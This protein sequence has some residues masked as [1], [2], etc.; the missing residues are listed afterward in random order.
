MCAQAEAAAA[1]AAAVL[2]RLSGVRFVRNMVV[3]AR[4]ARHVPGRPKNVEHRNTQV[5]G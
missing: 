5:L 4:H 2:A 1:T 3:V